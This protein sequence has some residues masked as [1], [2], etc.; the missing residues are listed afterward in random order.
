LK[1]SYKFKK[2]FGTF[3][4]SYLVL[5]QSPCPVR[6]AGFQERTY[7]LFIFSFIYLQYKLSYSAEEREMN[8][9]K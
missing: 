4:T 3:P 9:F 5:K 1:K 2:L 7:I 8:S 6:Q